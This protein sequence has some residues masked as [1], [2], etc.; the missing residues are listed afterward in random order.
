MGKGRHSGFIMK[1]QVLLLTGANSLLG[2]TIALRL[3]HRGYR[4]LLHYRRDTGDPGKLF[5]RHLIQ[6]GAVSVDWLQADL[7]TLTG[8]EELAERAV[9]TH[10]RVDVLINNAGVFLRKPIRESSTADF[11]RVFGVNTFAPF[12]L[13]KSLEQSGLNQVVNMLDIASNKSWK[14]HSIY[15]ASKAALE[16]FTRIAA[17]EFAPNIRVNGVAPGLISVPEEYKEQYTQVLSRIPAGRTGRA[18]EVAACV[19]FLLGAPEYVTGHVLTVDG[20][21]SLR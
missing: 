18:D 3:A 2:K 14:A 4:F 6:E 20:G 7:S 21:L 10:G 12:C 5:V 17:V 16:A 15:S 11:F 19:E 13:M 1:E 8:P 9:G